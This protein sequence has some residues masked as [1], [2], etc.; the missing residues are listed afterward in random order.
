MRGEAP[1]KTTQRGERS[2]PP[3]GGGSRPLQGEAPWKH[4]ALR[5][6]RRDRLDGDA[7]P[8]GYARPDPGRYWR[9]P[10]QFEFSRPGARS[11]R[12]AVPI[13]EARDRHGV[14]HL[15]EAQKQ[16]IRRV[17]RTARTPST[18][19]REIGATDGVDPRGGRLIVCSAR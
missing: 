11:P 7:P 4:G 1:H 5:G 17:P 6:V 9:T 2:E 15:S 8:A 16:R 14:R 19:R 3:K 18:T 10:R 12:D 13:I